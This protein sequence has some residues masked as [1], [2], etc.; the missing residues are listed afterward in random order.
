[1]NQYF[2]AIYNETLNLNH[3]YRVIA[4]DEFGAIREAIMR[5]SHLLTLSDCQFIGNATDKAWATS[6]TDI[7][8]IDAHKLLGIHISRPLLVCESPLP[9]LIKDFLNNGQPVSGG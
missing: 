1:M 5:H 9:H 6:K 3:P 8:L 7:E 2:V 4:K